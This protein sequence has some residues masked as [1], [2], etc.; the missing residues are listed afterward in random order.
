MPPGEFLR[1]YV[2]RFSTVEVD[3]T[4]YAEPARR[5]VEGSNEKSPSAF[6]L[7]AKVPQAI[8]HEKGLV[9]CG[10]DLRRFV[11]TASILVP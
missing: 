10:E 9:D 5:R 4:F 7:V 3:A 11:D 6:I 8:T 2:T 1:Y